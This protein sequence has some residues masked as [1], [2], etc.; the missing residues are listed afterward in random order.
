VWVSLRATNP[1]RCDTLSSGNGD[2]SRIRLLL[3]TGHFALG[4]FEGGLE[5][6]HLDNQCREEL[7]DLVDVL[8]LQSEPKLLG[9]S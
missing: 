4:S 5:G 3:Q 1:A 2:R 8:A 9:L 6:R 7:V